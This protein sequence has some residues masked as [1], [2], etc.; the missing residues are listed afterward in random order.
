MISWYKNFLLPTGLLAGTVIGAG[1]FALP[2][3]FV[4]SGL[5]IGF[6]TLAAGALAYVL[7]H[8]LYADLILRAPGEHR[9]PGYARMYLGRAPF[10]LSIAMTVLEMIFVMTIYLILS[11]SFLNLIAAGPDL[12]NPHTTDLHPWLSGVG[13]KLL[14]FWLLGSL[15]IFL[16]I[17]RLAISEF[18]VTAA[19]VA[20][21]GAIFFLGIGDVGRIVELKLFTGFSN[22]L[23]PLGA[24]LFALSG[25]VAIPSLVAYF[26]E[27][28]IDH[29][30]RALR[31]AIVAGTLVPAGLYAFFVL[32]ILGLSPSVSEDAISGLVGAVPSLLLAAIG[33]LGLLSLWSSYI[34]V[35]LDVANILRYDLKFSPATRIALVVGGPLLL[36]LMGFQ[37]FIPLVGFVGGIFLALEGI[38]IVTMWLKARQHPPH[39][40]PLLARI[41]PVLSAG[42]VT[43]LVIVLL[44]EL[45]QYVSA[46]L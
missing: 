21:I 39:R 40:P 6:L 13:V 32:G 10:W 33:V 19:M 27:R 7:L 30:R 2:Y 37:E 4:R 18:L 25:R 12:V 42:T 28:A 35:G 23:L 24:A 1:V 29:G 26:R 41:S 3:L 9:F 44:H 34:V 16:S 17:R 46:R 20:I 43:L 8:L 15:A 5:G 22:M 36:Y 31:R 14:I 11:V 45:Y 38:L